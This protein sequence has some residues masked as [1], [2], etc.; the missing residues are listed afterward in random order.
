MSN[1]L[2]LYCKKSQDIRNQVAYISPRWPILVSGYS[3]PDFVDVVPC[4]T[5][6]N[7]SGGK[8]PAPKFCI[9]IPGAKTPI[10]RIH[11]YEYR[12]FHLQVEQIASKML[13]MVVI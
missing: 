11:A 12:L 13:R 6:P 9:M 8:D 7:L 3:L 1:F 2:K 4:S 5:I 10:S